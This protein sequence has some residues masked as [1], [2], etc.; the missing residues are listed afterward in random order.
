MNLM[1]FFTELKRRN[2]YKVAIA[3]GVI[4]WL[5]IQIATQTF[6]FFEIP[7]WMVRSVIVLLLL[8]FPIALVIAW[9]F[10]LTPEGLKR[11]E[12]AD[13]LPKKAPRNR[14]WIYV[15]IVAGAISVSLFFVGRYTSSKQS[16][17]AELPAKSI[18]VLPFENLSRDPDN[19]YFAE[20]VRDELLARLSKAADLKV[21]SIRSTEQLK[22]SLDDLSQIARKFGVA[23]IL[24]GS[25]Q[26]SSD[27]VRVNVQLVRGENNTHLWADTFDRKLTDIFA[28]ES[29]IA[30]TIAE[31]LQTKFSGSEERAASAK[32]TENTEAHQLYLKG[33]YFWNRRTG[34]NLKKALAY[35]EQAAEKDPHYALAYTGIADSCGLIPIYSA[36]TSQ[37]YHPRQR[38]AAQKAVELDDTLAEAHTSL[39]FV[40][41]YDFE[42]AQ[43]VKEFERAIAL[44]P[45]YAT[46]HHFYAVGTLAA[47]GEFDRAI[48]EVKRALEL[49]PV[50]GI[51]SASLGTVYTMARRYDEAIAQGRETVEMHPEFYWAHRF[52]GLAL[53]LKGATSEAITE[54]RKAFELYDD[55]VVLALLAHAEVSIGKQNEARQ[56]LAQLTEEA[57]TRYVPAYAFAV[58]HLALGEKDQALD[59]LEKA[60][61]GHDGL[62]INLIKVDPYLDPLR[63]DPRFEALV[64]A[65]L[66][67]S[68]K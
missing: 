15:V 67:G 53:E 49:D 32:P 11:T 20:G 12:F 44:N 64:S 50:S 10:E 45:N 59:W 22:S 3:Y 37:E 19:A 34:E 7:N 42:F 14:A 63:G 18:A 57:K 16:G 24:A 33:R 54:Y 25:V 39:A 43:A 30:K 38:A 13:E 8:G 65:I 52:L 48:A 17:G 5:L 66:S 2:V 21:I 28:I 26:R 35:F 58:I 51:I 27:Q 1:Q 29:D 9:A 6:P 46:A 31:K 23:N 60:A 40:F 4:A 56:I 47:L 68:V 61:R 55:P 41:A 36:G 62:F